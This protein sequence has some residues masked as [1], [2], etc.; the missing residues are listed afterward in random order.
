MAMNEIAQQTQS[1][2][3]YTEWRRMQ[4]DPDMDEMLAY[5]KAETDEYFDELPE[6]KQRDI[7]GAK[8]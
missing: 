6:K 3:D 1:T 5:F 8:K 2:F 7:R 4:S